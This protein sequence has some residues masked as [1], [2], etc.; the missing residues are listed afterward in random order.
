[1]LGLSLA[2]AQA[3]ARDTSGVAAI[4]SALLSGVA[5]PAASRTSGLPADVERALTSYRRRERLFN[6]TVHPPRNPMKD[7]TWRVEGLR[8]VVF[9]LFDRPD[10]RQLSADLMSKL[11]VLDEWEGMASSPLEEAASAD[12]FL[13]GDPDSPVADYV[14][15]FSASRKLCA[16]SGLAGLDSASTEG[17]QV[18]AAADADLALASR[19]SQVLIRVAAQQLSRSRAC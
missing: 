13:I 10:S 5:M 6:Q 3:R 16:V 12:A 9:A 11:R 19:S 15:L 4:A 14:R 18:A 2:V 1:M 7:R 8:R 17:H